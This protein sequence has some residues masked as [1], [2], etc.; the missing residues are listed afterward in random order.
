MEIEIKIHSWS[1]SHLL[2][3]KLCPFLV[4]VF[5]GLAAFGQ[6][7][8][9]H[10]DT[11]PTGRT[12]VVDTHHKD[13]I[14]VA[15]KNQIGI[16]SIQTAEDGK[17]VGWLVLYKDSGGS[18]PVRGTLVVWRGGKVVRRFQTDQTFWSWAFDDAHAKRVAYHVGAMHGEP[19]ARCEL[20]D[21][22]NGRL[23]LSWQGDLQDA[24]R[25]PWTEGLTH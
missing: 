24:K 14:V 9:I 23:V 17:T 21:V 15:E 4:V 19:T 8:G 13:H 11:A 7:N 18:S 25:P 6:A 12:H 20:H 16:D 10:V 5:S 2:L 22:K 3:N 1:T